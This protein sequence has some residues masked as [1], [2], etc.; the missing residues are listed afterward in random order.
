MPKK[1]AAAFLSFCLAASPLAGC[2]QED[3]GAVSGAASRDFPVTV[4]GVTLNQAPKGVVVL[5]SSLAEVILE[6]DY[7]ISLKAKSEDCVQSD[8]SV[9]PN[10]TMDDAQAMK[11]A[12]ADLVLT[13]V[14]PTEEQKAAL[15]AAGIQV[16]T[17]ERATSRADLDRLYGEV[18]SALRGGKTGYTRGVKVSQSIFKGI[19]D[20]SRLIPDTDI[21]TSVCYLYNVEGGV[22][23]GDTLEGKLFECA[24]L[25]NAASDGTGNTMDVDTL[26]M[27]QPQYV[28]CPTGLKEQLAATEGYQ[29]LT[30]VKEGR[31]YEMDPNLML[32]Q[33][34]NMIQAVSF[35]AG[36]VYPELLEGKSVDTVT[37]STPSSSGSGSGE[38][39]GTTSA[40]TGITLQKGDEGDEVLKLQNRLKELGYLFVNATGTFAEGTEQSVKDFQLL[41][42][43]TVTG[44]ADPET[45]QKIYSDDAKPRTN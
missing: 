12:G 20:I 31:V 29:D 1:L 9:L 32:W 16:M 28:F 38:N 22:V 27:V 36:T 14:A 4:V 40:N 7:E 44:I 3:S 5:S 30:A 8:L 33:G 45:L 25:V 19:D 41:N 26:L 15:D 35:M 13:E 17:I 23:T 42:G 43:M 6:M 37:S 34:S 11:D 18:G 24:G 39:S 10:V 21:L 2:G